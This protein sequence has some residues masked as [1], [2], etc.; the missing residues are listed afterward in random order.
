VP[1]AFEEA[2]LRFAPLL[3]KIAIRKFHIPLHEAEPLVHDVFATYFLRWRSVEMP[4]R[5]LVGAI[6]NASRKYWEDSD[7]AGA[8]FCGETPCAATPSDALLREVHNKLLLARLLG[9]IGA[10]CRDLLHRYYMNGETTQAIAACLHSTPGT[11]LVLLHR[12]RKRALAAYHSMS[13]RA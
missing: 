12:C 4:E 6:C 1:V 10:K 8:L 11:V 5:Y 9:C 13:E 2:Y 3:R 7:A